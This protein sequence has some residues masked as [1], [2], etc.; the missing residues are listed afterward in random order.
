M[1]LLAEPGPGRLRDGRWGPG[2]SDHRALL[3]QQGGHPCR[4]GGFPHI[5]PA[6][7]RSPGGALPP[8]E[9]GRTVSES[10]A[11]RALGRGD[12]S[13]RPGDRGHLSPAPRPPHRGPGA[14]GDRARS[15]GAVAPSRVARRAAPGAPVRARPPCDQGGPATRRGDVPGGGRRAHRA[16]S[17][18]SVHRRRGGD[19]TGR[20]RP[21]RR[22]VQP[23]WRS[24]LRRRSGGRLRGPFRLPYCR[25]IRVGWGRRSS[26]VEA[27]DERANPDRARRPRCRAAGRRV[28]SPRLSRR[29]R[30]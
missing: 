11:V 13:R 23:G 22:R 29:S 15:H 26:P 1:G 12:P 24:L 27:G 30:R 19:H 17:S 14:I 5:P 4:D 18:S 21:L 9:L 2:G 10:H 25:G 20:R 8:G 28:C 3:A 7:W 6:R 16:F